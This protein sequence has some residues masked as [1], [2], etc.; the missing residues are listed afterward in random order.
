MALLV[1]KEEKQKI[2][3]CHIPT[4][5]AQFSSSVIFDTSMYV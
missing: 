3:W 5:V 2:Q 4:P 1:Y